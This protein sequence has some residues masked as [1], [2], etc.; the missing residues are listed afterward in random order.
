MPKAQPGVVSE[1]YVRRPYS[2]LAE[3][4]LGECVRLMGRSALFAGLSTT[5]CSQ[6]ATS[7]RA[8]IFSRRDFVFIQG[9]PVR[10]AF[11]VKSGCIKISL[12][13]RDGREVILRLSGPGDVVGVVGMSARGSHTWSAQVVEDCSGFLWEASHF[14]LFFEQF[15]LIRRNL[16]AILSDRLSELEERFREIATERVGQRV[17]H[18]LG[19]LFKKIGKPL[20]DG[21]EINLSREELAQMTGTT[22]FTVSRLLSAW[23]QQGFV[24]PKREAVLVRDVQRLLELGDNEQ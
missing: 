6:I 14:D 19:R 23:E 24:C 12:L 4:D 9:Q 5:Q 17:A 20:D 10:Q 1:P 16:A 3:N 21:C 8:R 2:S 7:G 11:L 13:G 22:L 18:E 15:P